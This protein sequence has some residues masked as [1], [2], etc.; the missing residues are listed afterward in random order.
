MVFH[1]RREDGSHNILRFLRRNPGMSSVA[2]IGGKTVGVILCGHDGRRGYIYRMAVD[3][4]Y[5]RLG[6]GAALAKCAVTAFR[7]ARIFRCIHFIGPTNRASR[8]FW[9]SAGWE[10][11]KDRGIMVRDIQGG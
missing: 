9:K 11:V 3:P 4:Q 5:R 2:I 6:I 10:L 7:N 8:A 1:P